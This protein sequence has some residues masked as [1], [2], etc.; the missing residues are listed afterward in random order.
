MHSM[1]DAK[2]ID[3]YVPGPTLLPSTGVFLPC[4]RKIILAIIGMYLFPNLVTFNLSIP[5]PDS[6]IYLLECISLGFFFFSC[7]WTCQALSCLRAFITVLP[8]PEIFFLMLLSHSELSLNVND[9]EKPSF[10]ASHFKT[11][12]LNLDIQFISLILIPKLLSILSISL[13]L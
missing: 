2:A 4:L 11:C 6:C 8:L 9:W 13:S 7:L 12:P 1:S 3:L 5:H 10:C